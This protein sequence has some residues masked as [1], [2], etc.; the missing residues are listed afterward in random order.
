MS[1]MTIGAWSIVSGAALTILN[2]ELLVAACMLPPLIMLMVWRR[3]TPVAVAVSP[4]P[5]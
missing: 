5:S 4:A 3:R 1:V 2:G